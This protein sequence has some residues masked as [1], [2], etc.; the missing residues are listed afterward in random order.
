M[1]WSVLSLRIAALRLG[2]SYL[3]RAHTSVKR[4]AVILQTRLL[5]WMV[6]LLVMLEDDA[7]MLAFIFC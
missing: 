3:R 4:L 5:L 7:A 2:C 1:D 6:T